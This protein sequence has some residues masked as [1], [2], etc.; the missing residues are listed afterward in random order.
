MLIASYV[1]D[2]KAT[3]LRDLVEPISPEVAREIPPGISIDIKEV[4]FVFLKQTETRWAFGLRLGKSGISLSEL[5]I[6]GS[7]LPADQTLAVDALQIL[8]SSGDLDEKQTKIINPLLP[9]GVAKLPET[10]G[11]GIAFDADVILGSTTKHLHAGVT[12]P[13]PALPAGPVLPAG[14]ELP[15]ASGL[16]AAA[17]NAPATPASS[18]DPVKW[19]DVNKQFGV[20]SFERVGVGYQN[21]V[22][23]FALDASVALGPG[24][25]LDAGAVGRLAAD[26]V[27][28]AVQHQRAGAR[29]RPPAADARRRIPEGQ[30]EGRRQGVHLL[31]RPGDG[32]DEPLWATALGG[33]APDADPAIVLHLPRH[34]VPIG[35]PPLLF[36]TGLAGGFGVNSPLTP[37]DDR[38][39]RRLPA[40]ACERAVPRGQRRPRRSRR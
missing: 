17:A 35:G 18:T 28:P 30:G 39:G 8:Y 3:A 13:K 11:K 26:G 32:Q 2:A 34:H 20:F 6:V 31:L 9:K 27:R 12:P 38:P 23:E 21:N 10:V 15:A 1:H 7:R 29:L 16:P 25:V 19:L 24:G 33:W 40:A 5:P 36:I 4:K 14:L 22:L 37:A